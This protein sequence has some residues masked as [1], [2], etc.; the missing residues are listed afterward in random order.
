MIKKIH[1][2]IIEELKTNTKTDTIFVLAAIVLNFIGLGINSIFS[3][4]MDF[5]E[6]LIFTIISILIIIVNMVSLVGLSKGKKTREKLLNGLLKMYKDQ[7]V[8]G[9]YDRSI[10]QTYNTRYNLFT[11]AVIATGIVALIIPIILFF[12]T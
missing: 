9:Y 5:A 11:I 4:M 6:I 12:R 3:D 7:N 8:E 10:L 2:H 1:E